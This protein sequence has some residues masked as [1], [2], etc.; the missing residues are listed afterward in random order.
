MPNHSQPQKTTTLLA[1]ALLATAILPAAAHAQ[2]PPNPYPAPAP[3]EQYLI[4]DKDAEI[5]LARTAAPPSVSAQAEILV[6]GR[7]GYTTAVKGSNDFTCLV[8]RGF[9]ANTDDSVFWNPKNRSPICVNA[10]GA[11]THLPGIQLK[12]KLALAGKSKAE[13]SQALQSARDAK[14]I[15]SPEP[16]A[17]SYMMSKQQYLNDDAV[18]WHPHLMFFVP[19]DAASTWGANLPGSQVLSANDPEEAMTIFFVVVSKWSDGSPGPEMTH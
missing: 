12:A 15:P 18:H 4:A 17:M 14:Q 7:D 11:R 8:E 10:A 1:F 3:V 5:A 9:A 19:G 13:I 6:L 2:T 16:G